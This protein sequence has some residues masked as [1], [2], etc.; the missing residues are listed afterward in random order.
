MLPPT[1][2]PSASARVSG[3]RSIR[4]GYTQVIARNAQDRDLTFIG[5]GPDQT[6]LGP[7]PGGPH[8]SNYFGIVSRYSQDTIRD[9]TVTG[10]YVGVY[11]VSGGV[12]LVHCRFVDCAS[13]LFTLSPEGA[14][15]TG[16]EFVDCSDG[17]LCGGDGDN[18][19]VSDCH[20][21]GC[22][23]GVN[24]QG[25]QPATHEVWDCTFTQGKTAAF[26][27]YGQATIWNCHAT[28]MNGGSNNSAVFSVT[29][30][31]QVQ[32]EDCTAQST[33]R[34]LM[35]SSH[36]SVTGVNLVFEGVAGVI[37]CAVDSEISIHQS[38]F[39]NGGGYTVEAYYY[40]C[41]PQMPGGLW[42]LDLTNNYWGT[43]DVAQI[44]DWIFIDQAHGPNCVMVDYLPLADG[45]VQTQ[46]ETWGGIKA[47]F[48]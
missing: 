34:A 11:D 20:F 24:L 3:T 7:S 47:L 33:G 44:E 6:I 16:C 32:L 29:S 25:S 45:P 37:Y 21:T 22:Y 1:A 13:G 8:D 35:A 23:Q 9:L 48:E 26:V 40:S 2:T 30:Y 41:D 39:L 36:S 42:H 38:H 4:T 19:R 18:V 17:V 5:S 27:V 31:A 46:R 15:V 12:E 28:L 43:T 14:T 10:I